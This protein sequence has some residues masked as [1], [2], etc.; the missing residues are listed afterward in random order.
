MDLKS[1][2]AE[3][4]AI[5]D[6]ALREGALRDIQ[7]LE[8]GIRVADG[9]YARIREEYAQG[10]TPP[11]IS[12]FKLL[13]MTTLVGL[14]AYLLARHGLL[15][16]IDAGG[17]TERSTGRLITAT[18]APLSY[19]LGICFFGFGSALLSVMALGGILAFF[20]YPIPLRHW[21]A[22]RKRRN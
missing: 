21:L 9:G 3:G 15:R 1:L 20:T 5:E 19:W 16:I 17:Y 14:L 4:E 10:H 11:R 6:R 8:D 13:V 12:R 7:R 2:R 18:S 22:A